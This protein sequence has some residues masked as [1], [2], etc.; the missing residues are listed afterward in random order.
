MGIA[1]LIAL[2]ATAAAGGERVPAM[3]PLGVLRIPM[4]LL[5]DSGV[6]M[7]WRFDPSQGESPASSQAA[8]RG[9]ACVIGEDGEVLYAPPGRSCR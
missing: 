4:K 1:M 8:K 2:L 7:P 5:E 6:P 9:S 3:E